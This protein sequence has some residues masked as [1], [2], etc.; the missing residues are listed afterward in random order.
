VR[1]APSDVDTTLSTQGKRFG[2]ISAT[3]ST[4]L[5]PGPVHGGSVTEPEAEVE[6]LLDR[7]VR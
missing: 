6:R 1:T 5:Q 2:C 3:R 7:L 4:V